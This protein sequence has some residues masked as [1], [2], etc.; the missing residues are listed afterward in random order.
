MQRRACALVA[1][2]AAAVLYLHLQ[3]SQMS[4]ALA[5]ARHLPS[6]PSQQPS[7]QPSL[8]PSQRH[9]T[10]TRSAEL[11]RRDVPTATTSRPDTGAQQLPPASPSSVRCR[12]GDSACIVAQL[13]DQ[14]S[15]T[16]VMDGGC[17]S[18]D[19]DCKDEYE[20]W[21]VSSAQVGAKPCGVH[22]TLTQP[23]AG[24]SVSPD[25]D[26]LLLSW[27]TSSDAASGCSMASYA[28]LDPDESPSA[29]HTTVGS[30]RRSSSVCLLSRASSSPVH[31]QLRSQHGGAA[32]VFLRVVRAQVASWSTQ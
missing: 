1:L 20:R 7:Q 11:A 24:D 6:Q 32:D 21:L 17:T 28:P 3:R 30:V 15:F 9:A 5:T 26:A 10:S 16:G 14:L 25:S 18:T 27:S 13:R 23:H 4:Q 31:P 8:Q 29:T 2:L 12:P 19:R 22:L